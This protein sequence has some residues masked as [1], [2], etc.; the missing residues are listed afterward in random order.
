MKQQIKCPHCNEIFPIE[1]SLKHEAE[2]YRKKLQIEEKEKS[3]LRQKEFE[4]SYKLKIE[5]Q[6]KDHQVELDKLKEEA[7][8]KQKTE[9]AKLAAEQVKKFKEASEHESKSIKNEADLRAKKDKREREALEERLQ[10]QEKAHQIDINRMRSKAEETARI[11]NQSPVE[12]KGEAQEEL[13]E[14]FLRKNFPTDQY[15]PVK[16]GKKGA[17]VIQF[18]HHKGHEVGKVLYESKDVLN[19]DEKWVGKLID[20]MHREDAMIGIIFTKV[21]P[22]K[23][24][25]VIEVREGGRITICSDQSVL[26]WVVALSRKLIIQQNTLNNNKKEDISS[27]LQQLHDYVNSNEFKLQYRKIRN[28]LQATSD[29]LEKDE[30]S[31]EIQIKNR[32]KNLDESKKN[33]HGVVTSLISNAGLPDD[34]LL[35]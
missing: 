25:G 7:L 18:V 31:F 24:K 21:M 17:D 1:D 32:K 12:R 28:N 3:T 26:Q 35:E 15:E 2:E 33:I 20:D 29:Q 22:K 27:K 6:N 16:K 23:S 11:A 4:D 19:F 34:L 9:A 10:K 5:K 30:R 14:E 8:K 13:I